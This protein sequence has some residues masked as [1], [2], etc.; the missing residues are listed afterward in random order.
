MGCEVKKGVSMKYA[1]LSAVL[2]L[3]G[4]VSADRCLG[5]EG[6]GTLA[7]WKVGYWLWRGGE[8]SVLR[9]SE[10]TVDLLYVQVGNFW[11]PA[12]YP[13]RRVYPWGM[14]NGR[15]TER[16]AEDSASVRLVDDARWSAQ[17]PKAE[18]YVAVWRN[19]SPRTPG[20]DLVPALLVKYREL[21]RQAAQAG[22]RLVGLQIDHDCPTDSLR[23]YARFLQE[24][25]AALPAEDLLSIT[26]LLD[27]FRSGTGIAEVLQW[28]NE[29]VPQFYD[30]DSTW[31]GVAPT[32][33]AKTIDSSKW[34]PIFNSYGRPYRIGIATFGRIVRITPQ[35]SH[36]WEAAYFR[37]LSPLELAGRQELTRVAELR[38]EAGET[39]VR[40]EAEREVNLA[41]FPLSPG[42]IIEMILPSQQ[43][44][45]SAYLA[46]KAL[47]GLCA[48]VVFFR[49]PA[50]EYEA[51]VLAPD[52]IQDIISE[53]KLAS[54][55][56]KLEV[57]QGQC[58]VVGCA[59]LYVRLGDRFS[60]QP[61]TLWLSSSS[62]L[63]Y[64][65]P[66]ERLS[67]KIQGPRTVEIRIP[68]Y[69]GVP[70]LYVGRVVTRE[71][72]Q[73]TLRPKP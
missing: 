73:F 14:L 7:E 67:T 8:P 68:P 51:L 12:S 44:V 56:T 2:L 17:L 1:L 41:A 65:L 33:I 4:F 32:F 10:K 24:L 70:R 38:N 52:E 48:G 34:A 63:E 36:Q 45:H 23:E 66:A 19:T 20:T 42:T 35:V 18:A 9:V 55:P 69:V 49:W 22:Q 6:S 50:G 31:M 60:P 39:I 53:K 61:V 3:A 47:G 71:S 13:G 5:A 54:R 40:Y 46:A 37:Y 64:V 27:W 25:R 28:V 59:N 16:L 72:A 15:R 62:A 11:S 58:A 57:E 30:V 29:Y 43:S 26:A 21:K